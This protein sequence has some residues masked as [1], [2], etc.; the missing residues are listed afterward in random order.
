MCHC[1][2]I[3][4]KYLYVHGIEQDYNRLSRFSPTP[5]SYLIF[6]LLKNT[7]HERRLALDRSNTKSSL[8]GR[9]TDAK[10][11]AMTSRHAVF[12]T[13]VTVK[14]GTVCGIHVITCLEVIHTIAHVHF[15]E[16]KYVLSVRS[17]ILFCVTLP[18]QDIN[19]RFVPL[20]PCSCDA[21]DHVPANRYCKSVISF[22]ML[23]GQTHSHVT[24]SVITTCTLY[25]SKSFS[26]TSKQ[27][28]QFDVKQQI[29][30]GYTV[31]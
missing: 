31:Y 4:I 12:V 11:T 5:L 21:V 3:S 17:Q 8:K 25:T 28:M 15:F 19:F 2:S 7:E 14:L 22:T 18:F 1:I 23:S 24:S 29:R 26:N 27:F 10:T 6:E 9:V 20:L 13:D 30:L 16:Y